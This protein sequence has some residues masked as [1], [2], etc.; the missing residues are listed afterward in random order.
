MFSTVRFAQLIML[1]RVVLATHCIAEDRG[2]SSYGYYET[3]TGKHN[4]DHDDAMMILETE[5]SRTRTRMRH[6]LSRFRNPNKVNT[7]HRNS[8][9]LFLAPPTKSQARP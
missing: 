6:I 9:L 8:K 2:D 5:R 3:T 1:L 7:L 4:D